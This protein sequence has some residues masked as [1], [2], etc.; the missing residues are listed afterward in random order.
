MSGEGLYS[1]SDYLTWEGETACELING[2]PVAMSAPSI[3]HQVIAG[4]IFKQIS[5]YLEDKPCRVLS[6]PCD[7][8]LD[9]N[10]VFQ[11]DVLVVCDKTKIDKKRVT[12]APD[13]V[14]E[15]LS[16]STKKIDVK[17]KLHLYKKVGVSEYWLV[18][19]DEGFVKIMVWSGAIVD[20]SI[21]L[22]NSVIKVK[23]LGECYLDLTQAMSELRDDDL[24]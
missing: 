6:A 23:T 14:I 3:A 16:E 18:D 22:I 15:V 11:P 21:A 8:V 12:G 24:I 17:T 5:I 2:I 4:E 1:Y 9:D 7:V 20:E 13:V 10:N 19:I